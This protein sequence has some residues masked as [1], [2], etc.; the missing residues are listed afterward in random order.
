MCWAAG[1]WR[2]STTTRRSAAT[3]ATRSASRAPSPVLIDHYLQDAIEVDVD[4]LA[5]GER[6][7]CRR[8]HGAYRGGRH[9]FRRQRLLAAALLPDAGD[10]RRDRAPD[11]GAGPGARRRRADECAVRGQGRRHLRARGQSARHAHGAVRRQGHRRADRQDRRPGDGRREARRFA[12]ARGRRA[13][14]MSRSRRRC[15]RSPA[16][17]A[18]TRPRAGD[19]ID[20]RGDGA[21]RRFRARLRQSAAR[22]AAPSCRSKAASSSRCATTTSRR[23]SSRAAGWSR[24]GFKLVATGGTADSLARRGLAGDAGSTRCWKAAR[25]SST[26]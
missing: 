16:S 7:R 12:A 19:A 11:R 22:P 6:C 3:C 5:D 4:A 24:W 25:T 9:P 2:S 10:D 13:A 14:A 15:S 18:S 26:I 20:R 21:R 1:R 8:H 23:W 17:P